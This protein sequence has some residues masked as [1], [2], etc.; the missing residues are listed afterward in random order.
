M[1]LGKRFR[2]RPLEEVLEDVAEA[3]RLMPGTEKV[4]LLDGDAM[5]LAPERLLPVLEALRAAFPRLRRVG[6]Y[7]NASSVLRKDDAELARLRGAGLGILYFGLES[8]DDATLRRIVKGATRNE[9]V[10]AVRRAQAAGVKASVM[11]LL[12]I[13]GR[14]RWREH[15]AAT[16]EAVSEMSPRFFSLLVATPVPGT[17]FHQEVAAGR[18]T[19]PAPEETLEEI[20]AVIEGLR[21]EGTVFRANHASNWL[22]LEGRLPQDRDRL[23]E[24]VRAARRGETPLKP[25]WTRGL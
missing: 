15:A 18:V 4:F 1:Y 25:E 20:E 3:A 6:A 24:E 17:A 5:T 23:L 14:E 11:G 19:L 21:C 2:V 9:V 22:P 8:G 10:E 12:G 16:A 13:A 7:S